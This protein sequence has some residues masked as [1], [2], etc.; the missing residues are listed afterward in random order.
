MAQ[1]NLRQPATDGAE[2]RFLA[3]S[4]APGSSGVS[5]RG[6]RCRKAQV[7]LMTDPLY[8]ALVRYISCVPTFS[9]VRSRLRTLP[10]CGH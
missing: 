9:N 5:W 4:V 8:G 3:V 7:V 10:T 1:N 6:D 2:T